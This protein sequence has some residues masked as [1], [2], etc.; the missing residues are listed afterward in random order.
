MILRGI[1]RSDLWL[2]R[3]L[4]FLK[5]QVGRALFAVVAV[6]G[7]FS[8]GANFFDPGAADASQ[9]AFVTGLFF[10]AVLFVVA[11]ADFAMSALLSR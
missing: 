6:V 7:I 3:K 10:A 1:A 5:T 9:L 4:P 8:T 11:L 2:T